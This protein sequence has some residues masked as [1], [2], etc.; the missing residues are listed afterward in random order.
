MPNEVEGLAQ[1]AATSPGVCDP[2]GLRRVT[3]DDADQAT[4]I[5]ALAFLEDPAWS[6]AFSDPDRRLDHLR[7]WWGLHIE[8]AVPHEWVWMT[9][10]GSAAALWIPPGKPEL[11]EEGEA[12]SEP[13][14]RELLGDRA[15]I[16]AEF[17]DLF[18]SNHP[19]DAP[20]YYLSLL[21]THPD[22][23]GGGEGMGLLTANLELIDREG[24]PAY[25]ESSN[26]ANDHRYER[27]GFERVGEFT[28][29]DENATVATMWRDPPETG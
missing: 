21:G 9:E 25:L 24:M 8:S 27:L 2:C 5:L 23:R 15:D 26:S 22:H 19:N 14:L 13:L 20:S 29:P 28:R 7:A 4:E 17:I 6:W 10:D 12:R 16:V 11:S 3:A 1:L 18:E